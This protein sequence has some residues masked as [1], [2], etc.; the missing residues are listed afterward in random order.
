MDQQKIWE[1]FQSQPGGAD[2]FR[3]EARYLHI[4]KNIRSGSTALN[5]GVGRGGL[6]EILLGRGVDVYSIDPGAESIEAIRGRLGLGD[7]AC[8][9]LSQQIPF[10]NGKFDV[11]VMSEVLEHLP[12]DTILQT[13]S[14]VRRVLRAGG[15]FIGTVPAEE[16]LH[17]NTVVCPDCGKV[18]HR[19]G[20]V[21]TFTSD[22]LSSLL[23]KE[24]ASIYII[25][26]QFANWRDLNWKGKAGVLLKNALRT[27]GV[28]GHGESFFFTANRSE[29]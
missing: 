21:Q 7:K 29:Q 5:I 26:R 13:L 10:E 2:A 12:D 23:E 27:V 4:A 15:M 19:W 22:R 17:E 11:V 1:Y 18:F 20:H 16:S 6:E 3:S 14:E 9:G 24:F 25:R 8:V 28:T